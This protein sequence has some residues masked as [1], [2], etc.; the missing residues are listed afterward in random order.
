MAFVGADVTIGT[1]GGKVSALTD[2][3]Q[4]ESAT[5]EEPNIK[6]KAA[7]GILLLTF[8]AI[9]NTV[10]AIISGLGACPTNFIKPSFISIINIMGYIITLVKRKS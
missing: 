4:P 7:G 1:G 8:L 10:S 2:K 6:A 5:P 9:S 3:A